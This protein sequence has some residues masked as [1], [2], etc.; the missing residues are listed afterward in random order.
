MLIAVAVATGDELVPP[1]VLGFIAAGGAAIIPVNPAIPTLVPQIK[2]EVNV[3]LNTPAKTEV[4]VDASKEKALPIPAF[5]KPL[6]IVVVPPQGNSLP[7]IIP[8]VKPPTITPPA[9]PLLPTPPLKTDPAPVPKGEHPHTAPALKPTPPPTPTPKSHYTHR[10]TPPTI[11]NNFKGSYRTRYYAKRPP[12][13]TQPSP[14]E[15]SE[16]K[17]ANLNNS[18]SSG[19]KRIPWYRRNSNPKNDS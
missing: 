4:A 9:Q 16:I 2:P 15:S 5:I 7:I 3:K 17:P 10:H 11:P 1:Q 14:Y 8:A 18:R 12:S 6:P 19:T 13:N